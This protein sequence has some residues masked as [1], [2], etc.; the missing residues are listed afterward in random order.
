MLMSH[1]SENAVRRHV[2]PAAFH[3][4]P[5]DIHCLE[6]VLHVV[7][8]GDA[9]MPV[10]DTYRT[11]RHPEAVSEAVGSFLHT[12]RRRNPEA[13]GLPM[14]ERRG[15]TIERECCDD[16]DPDA[17]PDPEQR[18]LNKRN[19]A[20]VHDNERERMACGTPERF[21]PSHCAWLHTLR[22]QRFR[23]AR[24]QRSS[25]MKGVP[26]IIP[27]VNLQTVVPTAL[28][29][30]GVHLGDDIPVG[31][32]APPEAVADATSPL[33]LQ[34]AF[35]VLDLCGFTSYT[36][37]SG[38]MAGRDVLVSFRA[39][40]R[41]I[42]ARRGMRVARWVGDGVLLVGLS[43]ELAVATAVDIVARVDSSR[44]DVRAGVDVGAALL[45]DGDDYVGS[46]VNVASR[47]CDAAAKGEVVATEAACRTLPNWVVASSKRAVAVRGLATP[48]PIL[49]L[50][51]HPDIEVP[52]WDLPG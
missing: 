4:R 3:Q 11:W 30:L 6:V 41:T 26:P 2:V 19:E 39:L 43:P 12:R 1:D 42:A 45:F 25:T 23:R 24:S 50:G 7:E 13:A 46:A 37:E 31:A 28:R 47:L 48:I 20:A 27:Q 49:S 34:R 16:R 51:V 15:E 5:V 8:G 29:S 18:R 44:F 21:H 38:P 22:L 40:V 33:E 9:L 17:Q 35:A 32:L 52:G 36:W 14:A 10:K